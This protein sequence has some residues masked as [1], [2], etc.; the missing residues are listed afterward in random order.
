M[1]PR[2]VL[3]VGRLALAAVDCQWY[4]TMPGDDPQDDRTGRRPAPASRRDL[5][6]RVRRQRMARHVPVAAQ[7]AAGHDVRLRGARAGPRRGLRGRRGARPPALPAGGRHHRPARAVGS[8]HRG[9]R[10]PRHPAAVR[11]QPR[12]P[13]AGTGVR[14]GA[15]PFLRDGRAPPHHLGPAQRDVRQHH[16][17]DR[18][19]RAHPRLAADRR[20]G[21]PPAAA[22]D[23]RGAPGLRRRC[24]RLRQHPL[25][26]P[27]V[28]GV[29]APRGRWSRLP[30]RAVDAGRLTE[31]AR[32]DGVGPPRQHGRRDRPGARPPGPHTCAGRPALPGLRLPAAP[33]DRRPGRGRPRDLPA[34]RDRA[35][36]TQPRAS[37]VRRGRSAPPCAGWAAGSRTSR[38]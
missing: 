16:L 32:G 11:R 14:R 34:G 33:A 6:R 24:E 4:G 18:R 38:S 3:V 27:H 37:V 19:V 23:T 25:A 15:G 10:R 8:R 20:A 7:A 35:R 9:P 22:A 2:V 36:D 26:E 30:P 29:H 28:P 21:D 5:G 1:C 17:G 12:R 31:L 13:H